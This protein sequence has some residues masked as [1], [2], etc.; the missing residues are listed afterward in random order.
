MNTNATDSPTGLQQKLTPDQITVLP[1][2]MRFIPQSTL[3]DFDNVYKMQSVPRGLCLIINNN[4]FDPQADLKQRE[5]SDKDA[6]NLQQL[7]LSLQ[8]T[9]TVLRNTTAPILRSKMREF[10][11]RP[12]HVDM[13]SVVI[14]I[15]SHG[16][17][18]KIYTIDGELIPITELTSTLNGQ[19]ARGLIGKPKLIFIQACRGGKV[20][21]GNNAYCFF[22]EQSFIELFCTRSNTII[23]F[24]ETVIH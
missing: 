16:L 4:H 23:D 24:P 5:G 9:V 3:N 11:M 17:D 1:T 6:A 10:A 2:D 8:Y 13:D 22:F 19:N 20:R 7:F 18:G 14:C 21:F 12:E 15:L